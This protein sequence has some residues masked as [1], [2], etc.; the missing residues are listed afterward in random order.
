MPFLVQ[1]CILE[2]ILIILTYNSKYSYFQIKEITADQENA[3]KGVLDQ[4]T[5]E[6]KQLMDDAQASYLG[7]LFIFCVLSLSNLLLHDFSTFILFLL[8]FI[9]CFLYA[10][11]KVGEVEPDLAALGSMDFNILENIKETGAQVLHA[12]CDILEH[13]WGP[14]E[15]AVLLED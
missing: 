8:Y 1:L 10:A 11:C 7:T 5:K 14:G 4:P 12:H 13:E 3:I 6:I 2:N 15:T 9:L